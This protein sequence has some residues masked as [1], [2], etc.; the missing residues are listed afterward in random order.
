MILWGE[1]MKFAGGINNLMDS[2][3]A[4]L[5]NFSCFDINKMIVL[6][7]LIGSFKLGDILTKLMLYHQV[8][9][10]Q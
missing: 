10:E 6:A 5:D 3:I 9:V 4:E 1:V 7:A 8:A 2:W